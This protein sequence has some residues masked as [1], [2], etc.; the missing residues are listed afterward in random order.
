MIHE[1]C[2]A[3]GTI[4]EMFEEIDPQTLIENGIGGKGIKL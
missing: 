2:G 4:Q 3:C 1:A